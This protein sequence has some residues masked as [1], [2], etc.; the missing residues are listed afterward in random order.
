[1][2]RNVTAFL[3]SRFSSA[4]RK[5]QYEDQLKHFWDEHVRL[6]VAMDPQFSLTIKPH[7]GAIKISEKVKDICMSLNR[8]SLTPFVRAFNSGYIGVWL[9]PVGSRK[10]EDCWVIIDQ[11]SRLE[12]NTQVPGFLC[13][14][15]AG[16]AS[17]KENSFVWVADEN[18][19]LEGATVSGKE[20]D[21][22]LK[23]I[24]EKVER[25][26]IEGKGRK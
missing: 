1:M 14:H 16:I 26:I 22:T 3:R 18:V 17:T 24:Y 12:G 25:L 10:R 5:R 19:F 13:M 4:E 8:A 7:D 23:K 9:D 20:R 2:S 11:P 21:L 15:P 6:G